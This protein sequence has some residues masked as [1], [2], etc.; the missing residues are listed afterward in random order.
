MKKVALI[1]IAFISLS[2]AGFAQDKLEIR[3]VG[4]TIDFSS[5]NGVYVLEGNTE[6]KLNNQIEINLEVKNTSNSTKGFKVTKVKTNN[7]NE[8]WDDYISFDDQVTFIPN[9]FVIYTTPADNPLVIGGGFSKSM[10]FV[11]RPTTTAISNYTLYFGSDTKYEDSIKIE[12]NYTAKLSEIEDPLFSISPNPSTGVFKFNFNDQQ[13]HKVSV[14]DLTGKV[15]LETMLK[16]EGNI[17]LVNE[18]NGIY[19]VKVDDL[20]IQK[21]IKE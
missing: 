21:V 5:G 3:V 8:L 6:D 18:V 1:V 10:Q 7:E 4:R 19:F 12:L 9:S 17:Q 13:M 14:S 15:V 2:T 16:E 20:I 11:I